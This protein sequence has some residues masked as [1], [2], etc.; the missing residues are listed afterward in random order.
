[1]RERSSLAIAS[2][3]TLAASRS[4]RVTATS[5]GAYGPTVHHAIESGSHM[6]Q[7]GESAQ[8]KKVSFS[9]DADVASDA[10]SP[11]IRATY[12]GVIKNPPPSACTGPHRQNKN[13]VVASHSSPGTKATYADMVKNPLPSVCTGTRKQNKN[14][15]YVRTYREEPATASVYR[16]S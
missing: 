6:T 2:R 7:L 10:S 12:A 14:N 3:L 5:V 4:D 9:D 16:A 8:Y 11:G 15:G 1:M 13:N